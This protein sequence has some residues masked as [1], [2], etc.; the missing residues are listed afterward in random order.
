MKGI[1]KKEGKRSGEKENRE[2]EGRMKG[3]WRKGET[4]K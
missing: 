4:D 2:E 1:K 3:K